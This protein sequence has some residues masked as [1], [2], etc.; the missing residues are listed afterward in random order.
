MNTEFNSGTWQTSEAPRDRAI[1]LRANIVI[2]EEAV[3]SVE[4]FEDLARWNEDAQDWHD[5][6]GMSIRMYAD[7]ELV[8]LQWM[9]CDERAKNCPE[10][11]TTISANVYF[12]DDEWR[13]LCNVAHAPTGIRIFERS[14]GP[15]S[16][17]A[18]AVEVLTALLADINLQEAAK[19]A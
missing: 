13:A 5:A 12:W 14:E 17:R 11:E 9:E 4:P 3:M 19:A 6:R 18:Q 1:W 8:I 7:A 15:F 2:T 10:T 16:T